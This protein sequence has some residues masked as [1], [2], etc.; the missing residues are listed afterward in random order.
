MDKGLSYKFRQDKILDL[1]F[2]MST[3]KTP[4][5]VFIKESIYVVSLFAEFTMVTTSVCQ[6]GYLVINFS[7]INEFCHEY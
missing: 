2:E 5:E 6:N 4:F 1:L 7:R 3:L